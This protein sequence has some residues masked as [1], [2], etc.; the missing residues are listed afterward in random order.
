MIYEKLK[1][2][3]KNQL[4]EKEREDLIGLLDLYRIEA[5]SSAY[6]QS[7]FIKRHLNEGTIDDERIENI[8]S[9]WAL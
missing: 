4:K 7:A 2:Q 6:F 3:F 9:G 5:S 8:L 1:T